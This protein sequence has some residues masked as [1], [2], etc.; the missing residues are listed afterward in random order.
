MPLSPYAQ[1]LRDKV[2]HALLLFPGVCGLVFNDKNEILLGRRSDTGRWAV[3]GGMLD[4][5]ESPATAVVREVLEETAVVCHPE[6]VTG[7]YLTR[8]IT[9]PNGDQAQYVITAFRCRHVSGTPR[10]NDAESL[11]VCYFPLDALPDLHPDHR[12]RIEHAIAPGPVFFAAP[13]PRG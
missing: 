3:V 4:P 9:Y 12:L 11:E 1:S 13:A 8:V 5:G 6:R 7:V 2:G 10:V